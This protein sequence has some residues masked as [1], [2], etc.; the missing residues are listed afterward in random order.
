MEII[1][2]KK[3]ENLKHYHLII[4]K[5]F[6]NDYQSDYVILKGLNDKKTIQYDLKISP[7][8]NSMKFANILIIKKLWWS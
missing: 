1:C 3:D 8:C 2:T 6:R 5:K 7:P 4:L